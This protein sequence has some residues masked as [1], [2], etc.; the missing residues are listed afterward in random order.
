MSSD[1]ALRPLSPMVYPSPP[2]SAG[3][4]PGDFPVTGGVASAGPLRLPAMSQVLTPRSARGLAIAGPRWRGEVLAALVC[5]W[6]LIVSSQMAYANGIFDSRSV[7]GVPY[8]V[9]MTGAA[10]VLAVALD[11]GY[12]IGLLLRPKVLLYLLC[13]AAMIGV[14]IARSGGGL[15]GVFNDLYVV[16]W[17]FVGFMLMRVALVSGNTKAFLTC[18]AIIVIATSLRLDF[19]N[20]QGGQL[21]TSEARLTSVDFWPVMNLGTIMI[22]LLLTV[23]WPHGVGRV[24]FGITVFALLILLGGI[25]SSTRSLFLF[26]ALCFLLCLFALSRDPR[27]AGRG[28][29]IRQIMVVSLLLVAAFLAYR[30]VKGQ[31]LGGMTQLATRFGEEDFGR[32]STSS[33][34]MREAL[35][36]LDFLEPE[37]WLVGLGFGIGYWNPLGKG[38]WAGIP[39]IAVLG[40]LMKGG[41]V[42]LGLALWTLY[43]SPAVA[44]FKATV[45][46]RRDTA[47]PPPIL[48]VGPP[49]LAWACLTFVSGGIDIGS[50]LGLGALCAL[51]AQLADD[52]RR[53]LRS[54]AVAPWGGSR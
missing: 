48:V 36:F 8:H 42:V 22:G 2:D 37:A 50:F 10:L 17:F 14:G 6:G 35:E 4:V 5:L 9:L 54:R 44:F 16:R 3:P 1:A 21:S 25:R 31:M 28:R 41:I 15:L 53:F 7:A 18:A 19:R 23:T 30:I 39:H 27:M 52:E 32:R 40:W 11:G 47:L 33:Y 51:W 24:I 45:A 29:L 49:L 34:R 38:F 20:T 26:Q 12:M 13:L 43:I 46:A